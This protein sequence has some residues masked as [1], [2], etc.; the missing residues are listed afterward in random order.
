MSRADERPVEVGSIVQLRS[1][2]P[3]M[4]VESIDGATCK[5]VFYLHGL[6]VKYEHQHAVAAV[7]VVSLPVPVQT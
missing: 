3:V 1:G 5:C 6:Y 2:G 7:R 4:T